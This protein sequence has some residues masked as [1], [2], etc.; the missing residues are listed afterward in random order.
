MKVAFISLSDDEEQESGWINEGSNSVL[1]ISSVNKDNNIEEHNFWQDF[2]TSL[3]SFDK[4]VIYANQPGLSN[5]VEAIEKYN[6]DGHKFIVVTCHC[7]IEEKIKVIMDNGLNYATVVL[8]D[9]LTMV[10]CIMPTYKNVLKNGLL[11]V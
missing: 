10:T 11:I 1:I 8:Y 5:V 6:V 2:I 7:R 4:I 3:V 9:C